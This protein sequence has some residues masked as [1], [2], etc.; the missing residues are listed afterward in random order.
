MSIGLVRAGGA[1]RG[2]LLLLA[3]L[4]ALAPAVVLGMRVQDQS[5]P[6]PALGNG[7][8]IAQAVVTLEDGD[9]AWSVAR[10]PVP[11]P[12]DAG[13]VAASPGFLLADEGSVLLS[14]V[15]SD[16]RLRL[17][18]GEA[19]FVS[20][21]ADQVRIALGDQAGTLYSIQLTPAG[22]AEAGDGESLFTSEPFSSSA[23][24]RD[25]DL[26]RDRLAAD[27]SVDIPS[28]TLPTLLLATGGTLSVTTPGGDTTELAPGDAGSYAGPV[29]VA[30]GD[31]EAVFVAAVVGPAVPQVRIEQSE[32]AIAA[33][34]AATPASATA[35][36]ESLAA[37]PETE[38][39]AAA[40]AE[41]A[42]PTATTETPAAEAT[43]DAADLEA[44]DADEDALDDATEAELG[45]DP[46]VADSDGDGVLDGAEVNELGTD[47]IN[48]DTDADGV[49]DGDE[50]AAG[51]DPLDGADVPSTTSPDD[52]DGDGFLDAQ[53]LELGTDPS[54][55]DTDDDGLTDGDELFVFAT[56]PL[57]PD[58]DGDGVLDGD[59]INNGTDP[60]DPAS[61]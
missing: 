17:A 4:F 50:V 13:V 60:N 8:V 26:V 45:T 28:G 14:F 58:T 54:D 15:G 57:N 11:L 6:S 29:S 3:T 10:L 31:E 21:T 30:A 56:G 52:A 1:G 47:P 35:T 59:E 49:L 40:T 9:L 16:T 51:S 41:G 20:D 43:P 46:T 55:P 34:P 38:P 27:E 22:A 36:T 7:Q 37:T 5:D 61:L 25:V 19:T 33:T 24:D 18:S 48:T 42:E 32:P 39:T 23:S 12:P 44:V 53:E 2:P